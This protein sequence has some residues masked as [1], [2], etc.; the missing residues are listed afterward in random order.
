MSGMRIIGGVGLTV[1]FGVGTAYAVH[2]VGELNAK[3]SRIEACVEY[4]DT[5]EIAS[6]ACSEAPLAKAEANTLKNTANTTGTL[7]WIAFFGA[8][9]VGGATFEQIAREDNDD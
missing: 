3:A 4:N 7:G 8:I 6:A 9:S 5:H 2:E 1:A